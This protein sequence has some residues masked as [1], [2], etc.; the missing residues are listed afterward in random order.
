VT[1]EEVIEELAVRF[2]KL[3][4]GSDVKRYLMEYN[5]TLLGIYDKFNTWAYSNDSG[6]KTSFEIGAVRVDNGRAVAEVYLIGAGIEVKAALV[7]VTDPNIH[8]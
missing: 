8:R 2:Q 4:A 1:R 3:G 7:C 6:V 5:R